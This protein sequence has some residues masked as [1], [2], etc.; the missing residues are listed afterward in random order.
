MLPPTGRP[1]ALLGST[2]N[3]TFGSLDTAF[4]LPSNMVVAARIY[5]AHGRLVRDLGTRT[6]G[7]GRHAFHWDGTGENGYRPRPGVYFMRVAL[8]SSET[9][10][11][12]VLLR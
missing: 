12:L 10:S 3:P 1:L 5:D 2:P 9:T 8:G 7:P 4:D 6:Y 11:K